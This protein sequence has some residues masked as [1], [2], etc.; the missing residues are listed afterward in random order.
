MVMMIVGLGDPSG[1]GLAM[2]YVKDMKRLGKDPVN[3][4]LS[5]QEAPSITGTV[6][7][8][9]KLPHKQVGEMLVKEFNVPAETVETLDRWER[10]GV[11]RELS[12]QA[13]VAGQANVRLCIMRWPSLSV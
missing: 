3:R 13:C 4:M 5:K 12:N 10:I 1:R 8:L 7:D 2:S 9:R 11:L 6:S